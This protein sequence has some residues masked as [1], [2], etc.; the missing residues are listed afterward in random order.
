[1]PDTFALLYKL[2]SRHIFFLSYMAEVSVKD[3]NE[4]KKYSL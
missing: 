4:S 1:M 3:K 2:I